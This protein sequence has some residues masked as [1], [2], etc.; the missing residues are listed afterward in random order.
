MNLPIIVRNLPLTTR[1]NRE[2]LY[3]LNGT[4]L[5]IGPWKLV[6]CVHVSIMEEAVVLWRANCLKVRSHDA[7]FHQIFNRIDQVS[8]FESIDEM[9]TRYDFTIN[10]RLIKPIEYFCWMGKS[11]CDITIL[12]RESIENWTHFRFS[13]NFRLCSQHLTWMVTRYDFS[14][15]RIV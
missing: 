8:R 13:I 6:T 12:T 9:V 7:I 5:F 4:C 10:F 15:K 14:R 1:A 2:Y 3:I 11:H